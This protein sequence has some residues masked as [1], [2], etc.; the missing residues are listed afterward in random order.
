LPMNSAPRGEID[1]PPFGKRLPALIATPDAQARM[2]SEENCPYPPEARNEMQT[3]TVVLLV[4][5]SPDGSAA[6]VQLDGDGSSGSAVLN[7]AAIKCVREMGHFPP[8]I[9]DSKPVGYWAR[10][11]FV[12]SF[13]G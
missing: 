13:G 11:K 2:Q 5:V 6:N 3:G 7:L 9:V 8:K 10:T 12:W 1:R 4:Y